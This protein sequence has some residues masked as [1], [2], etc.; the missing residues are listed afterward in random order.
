MEL[1]TDANIIATGFVSDEARAN[2]VSYAKVLVMPSQHESF[3]L[4]TLEGW[5]AGVPAIVNGLSKVLYGHCVRSGAGLSY[6]SE[7]EFVMALRLLRS[8]PELREKMGAA[9]QAYVTQNYSW[10]M[11]SQQYIEFL[12]G[13]YETVYQP[14]PTIPRATA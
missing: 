13:V 14:S 1:P 11:I 2:W 8:Q 10:R 9:G 4:A 12:R 7:T 6:A 3:S 5:A